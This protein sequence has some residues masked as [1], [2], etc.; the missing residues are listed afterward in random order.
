MMESL[1]NAS[2]N[3]MFDKWLSAAAVAPGSAIHAPP[4]SPAPAADGDASPLGDI[5]AYLQP[6]S[7]GILTSSLPASG[8]FRPGWEVRAPAG[9][10]MGSRCTR[11]LCHAGCPCMASGFGSAV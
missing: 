10:H 5:A 8:T 3:T 2:K 7:A 9:S 4:R 6:P 11:A 1:R